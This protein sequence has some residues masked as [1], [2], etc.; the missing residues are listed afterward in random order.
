MRVAYSPVYI[1]CCR[2]R[3][4]RAH[5]A[6]T[7]GADVHVRVCTLEIKRLG[8]TENFH[9]RKSL[10]TYTCAYIV[11]VTLK[12]RSFTDIINVCF[13]RFGFFSRFLLILNVYFAF[14][15]AQRSL[16]AGGGRGWGMD[17]VL[18]SGTVPFL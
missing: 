2:L 17:L 4:G 9:K 11:R 7:C 5:V 6:I 12:Q 18:S 13:S 3:N 10:L 8:C 14:N 16:M 15:G 1:I